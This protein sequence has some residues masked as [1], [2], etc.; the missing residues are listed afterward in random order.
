MLKI[1]THPD[2]DEEVI[3][4]ANYY[5]DERDGYGRLFQSDYFDALRQ[6]QQDS[7]RW[8]IREFGF[9]KYVMRRFRHSIRYIERRD[10]LYIIAVPHASRKP[11]YWKK[12]VSDEQM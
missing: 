5:E 6:I 7:K 10:Y 3:N 2:A 9:R 11:G 1:R 4:A 12:R 8:P